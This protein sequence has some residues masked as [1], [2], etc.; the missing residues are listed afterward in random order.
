NRLE[1]RDRAVELHAGLGVRECVL[2][3]AAGEP[4]GPRR[5]V[6]ARDVEAVERSV[7]GAPPLRRGPL[8][9]GADAVPRRH[10]EAVEPEVE[11]G[12]AEVPDLVDRLRAEAV[13]ELASLLLDD[14]RHQAAGLRLPGLGIL[15]AAEEEDEVRVERIPAPALLAP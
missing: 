8:A 15:F 3:R 12:E 2:H 4:D 6:D 9:E 14:E 1:R 10:A 11:G 7:E 5:G 13:R